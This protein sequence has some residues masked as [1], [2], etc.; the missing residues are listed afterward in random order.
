MNTNLLF[1]T[2]ANAFPRQNLCGNRY[3]VSL[4]VDSLNWYRGLIVEAKL[5]RLVQPL[6][7]F[8]GTLQIYGS[9]SCYGKCPINKIDMICAKR[10]T[11]LRYFTKTF[12]G[13]VNCELLLEILSMKVCT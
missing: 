13:M 3:S 10:I 6:C 5:L 11:F 7:G 8:C 9:V 1:S 12:Q 2:L 4:T